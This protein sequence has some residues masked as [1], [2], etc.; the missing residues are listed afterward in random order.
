MGVRAFT[1]LHFSSLLFFFCIFFFLPI[2]T[3]V[4]VRIFLVLVADEMNACLPLTWVVFGS[5][6]GGFHHS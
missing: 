3:F 1:S 4:F 2:H 6:A 5:V